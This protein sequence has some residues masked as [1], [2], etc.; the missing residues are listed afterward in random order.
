MAE[1]RRHADVTKTATKTAT[2]ETH[3]GE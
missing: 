1:K 2:S 3:F